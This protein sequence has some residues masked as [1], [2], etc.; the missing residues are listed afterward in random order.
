MSLSTIFL[1]LFVAAALVLGVIVYRGLVQNY[2][3]KIN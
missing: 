1:A 2:R 3:P